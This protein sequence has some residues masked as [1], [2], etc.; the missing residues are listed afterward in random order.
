MPL[1]FTEVKGV[2]GCMS[3]LLIPTWRQVIVVE[4]SRLRRVSSSSPNEDHSLGVEGIFDR[5]REAGS[6]FCFLGG[7]SD[8][9]AGKGKA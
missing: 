1:R 4:V 5:S 6:T 8:D 7:G 2:V 9:I 3:S